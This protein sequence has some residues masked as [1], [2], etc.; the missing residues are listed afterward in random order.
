MLEGMSWAERVDTL[1]QLRALVARHP[2]RA[3]ELHQK[4]SSPSRKRSLPE[5]L[6]RYQAKQA[7]AQHKRQKLL[8]EKSQRLRELLN[9]VEDVKSA[10]SQLIEDKRI[11]MEMKLKRAEE[12][13]TQH[14]L[15]IVRK[16]HDE[17]S[18]LKEIAFINEL[19]AQ[20]KRHDFMALCQEQEERLQV[21]IYIPYIYRYILVNIWYTYPK[22]NTFKKTI[23]NFLKSGIVYNINM[24]NVYYYRVFNKYGL[25]FRAFKK[26][27]NVDKRKKL[28]KKLRLKNVEGLWKQSGSCEYKK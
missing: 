6:R 19:E 1:A 25:L 12:N 10:K 5:T 23:Q 16:A 18:K 4:L 28:P 11:R 17:D 8:M 20:N 26:N 24:Y 15:E 9:K 14:L 22:N 13:R 3:L 27:V 21:C 2:G 7:C